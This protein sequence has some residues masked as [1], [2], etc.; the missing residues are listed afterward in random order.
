MV[1]RIRFRREPKGK[2]RS[3]NRL[4]AL[5]VASLLPPVSLTA[6]LLAAWRIAADLKLAG[7]FAISQG[8]F[9]HWQ[10]WMGAGV[11]LGTCSHILNRY[12]KREDETAGQRQRAF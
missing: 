3:T 9:S 12:A 11:L 7:S 1:V 8:F 6:W 4:V 2:R 10:V 5:I